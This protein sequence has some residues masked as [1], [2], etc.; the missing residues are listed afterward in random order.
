MKTFNRLLRATVFTTLVLVSQASWAAGFM[1]VL[2]SAS[3][4]CCVSWG[5]HMREAGF[6]VTEIN[7]SLADLQA[8]KIEAGLK[9]GQTSCHTARID[10]Y[11]IEG[12]VPAG[13]VLRL[14]EER[15]D[16]IGLTV[17]DMP[18]GSPGMG[19]ADDDA[20]PYDVL[21]VKRDGTTEIY[22]SYR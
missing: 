7:V 9:P 11:V 5:K 6:T 22:A 12:H 19:E 13:E 4:G 14:L 21:L 15:P 2:K 8:A 18:Y 10:G 16:A 3:C 17:P 1:E 20:D